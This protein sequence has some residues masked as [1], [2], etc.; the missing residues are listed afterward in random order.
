MPLPYNQRIGFAVT[1]INPDPMARYKTSNLG[2]LLDLLVLHQ[3]KLNELLNYGQFRNKKYLRH[4]RS[5]AQI[6]DAIK[7]IID[8]QSR[9]RTEKNNS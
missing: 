6:Q 5:I 2:E 9:H 4:R 3:L 8:Q 1:F 7:S